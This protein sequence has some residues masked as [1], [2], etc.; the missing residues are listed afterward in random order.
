MGGLP[1][2]WSRAADTHAQRDTLWKAVLQDSAV[3]AWAACLVALEKG[4][5]WCPFRG[6]TLHPSPVPQGALSAYGDAVKEKVEA[7]MAIFK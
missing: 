3:S 4:V 6:A 7:V 2:R 1:G 5:L